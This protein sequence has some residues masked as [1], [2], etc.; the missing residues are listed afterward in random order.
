MVCSQT[1]QRLGVFRCITKH[2]VG[3][4]TR[5]DEKTTNGL[6][7]EVYK[8]YFKVGVVANNEE[9]FFLAFDSSGNVLERKDRDN[10]FTDV[11]PSTFLHSVKTVK[12]RNSR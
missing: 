7:I 3:F 10:E 4:S 6:C 8:D 5:A 2:C 12:S 1:N 11:K 9:R